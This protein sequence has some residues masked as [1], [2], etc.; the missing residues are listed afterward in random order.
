MYKNHFQNYVRFMRTGD[1]SVFEGFLLPDVSK[2]AKNGEDT[3]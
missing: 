1:E 3:L 2:G